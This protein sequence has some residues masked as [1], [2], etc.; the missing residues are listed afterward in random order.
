M[1]NEIVWSPPEEIVKNSKLT[2]FL[3]FCNLSEISHNLNILVDGQGGLHHFVHGAPL[4]S[5]MIFS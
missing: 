1:S 4:L 2:K 3:K 5:S